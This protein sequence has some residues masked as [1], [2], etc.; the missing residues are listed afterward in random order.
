[1]GLVSAVAWRELGLTLVNQNARLM[2]LEN[3]SA[4]G[5]DPD[6]LREKYR[7]GT[8]Q[9]PA[10]RRQRAVSRGEG[11]LRALSRRPVRRAG[12]HA[13]AAHRR[14]GSG[15]DRRRLRRTARGGAIARS[16]RR[17]HPHHREGRR[18]RRHLVLEP[19]SGRAVRHRGVHLSAAARRT[20]LHPERK[21]LARAG[22]PR[23]Q[24]RDRRALRPLSTTP[25]SRPK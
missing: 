13:R 1:M 10:R 16:R 23:A 9:A 6:A 8:R 11:R 24:P 20:E 12:L 14:S 4:L 19:L 15:R 3:R 18:L 7:A 22:D 21:I 5:F 17:R 25:A 2:T